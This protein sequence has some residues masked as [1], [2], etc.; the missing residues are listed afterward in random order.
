MKVFWNN[1]G[2]TLIEALVAAAVSIIGAS[3]CFFF[4]QYVRTHKSGVD[5]SLMVKEVLADNVVEVKGSTLADLPAPGECKIRVYTD[6]KK[7]VS[8]T[9]VAASPCPTP[10]L[11]RNQMQIAWEVALPSAIDATFSVP[12]MKLPSISTSLKQVTV[13]SWGYLD[14]KKSSLSHNQIVIFRK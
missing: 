3:L 8:E 10:S 11:A 7:F 2:I 13:H 14:S 5:N 1:H 9:T 4:I 12:G 6:K